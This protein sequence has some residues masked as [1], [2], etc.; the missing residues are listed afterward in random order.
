MDAESRVIRSGI[1]ALDQVLQGIWLGDN[2]VWQIEDLEIYQFFARPFIAQAIT[3]G[4]VCVYLR[5][6][7]HPPILDPQPGLVIIELDPSPGFDYFSAEVHRIIEEKGRKVFYVFD[8]LSALVAEWTTDELLANFFQLTCPYL[9]ELDTVA[10]F[11]LTLGKHHDSAVSRIRDTTQ[12]LIN[13]YGANGE[14]YLHPQK[15]WSRYSSQMFMP[16]VIQGNKIVPIFHSGD[17]AKIGVLSRK[18]PLRAGAESIAPWESVYRKLIQY[19]DCDEHTVNEKPEIFSLKQELTHMLLGSTPPFSDLA[20][21]YFTLKDLFNIRSRIIGSGRIGGKASGMLL[22]RR[23]LLRE[24]GDFDFHP[25]ID[26]HDSFYIGSDVFFTF[27]V[28]NNLF[29]LRM[30]LSRVKQIS[31]HDEFEEVERLFLEAHFNDEI[32][33]QFRNMLD[34][35]GQAPIIVRSSSFL[36]DSF[37]NAF[38]GKYRS[39]FCANQGTPEQRLESFLRAVKLVYASALN[40]DAL[41]YRNKRGLAD[42]D[43]QMALLVQRV[44]GMPFK[45]YFF[46]P[47]AGVAF[48]RNLY[49]WTD[50]IDPNKGIIRLVFGLGTRAVDRIGGDYPR[51]IAVSHPELRPEKGDKVVKYSQREI[52]LLDLEKNDLVTMPVEEI[53]SNADYPNQHLFVSIFKDGFLD[54]PAFV[55]L[56]SA[57]G[58]D[59][60]YS[61]Y[62][63]TFNNLIRKS[64]FV[65]IIGKMLAKLEHY[66]GLPVDTEFTAY[67]DPKGNCHVNLL[68]CRPLGLPGTEGRPAVIPG[69]ISPGDILFRSSRIVSSGVVKNV[70][71]VI[72]IDPAGYASID[73]LETKKLMGRIVGRINSH[74]QIIEGKSM[75]MGPGRWGSSNIDM[76][77]NAH[78]SDIGNTSVLVEIA[79]EEAGQVPEVSY[80][81]HFFQDLVEAKIVYLPVYP[82]DAKTEFNA[83][84][85]E[86]SPNVLAELFPDSIEYKDVIKVI[87]VPAATG[88]KSLQVVA[89][90]QTQNAL[91]YLA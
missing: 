27:L 69:D 79:R 52:D 60:E 19:R 85:F 56:D 62:V 41:S 40:P 76:G 67:I 6:A 77:V 63:L 8:S 3:D 37:G 21:R 51:M 71:Y 15:V 47:L 50:R 83:D 88:G 68:Q 75:M 29:R 89:N 1:P 14:H 36:E 42:Q 17:A 22:A 90:L 74:P 49:A 13:V 4:Y 2:V 44:C 18:E 81:T 45:K 38:A 61:E 91:C 59:G 39:E 30:H 9:F 87:D 48:S 43:E 53:L 23:I 46:P 35:F 65:E 80:G 25:F 12:L 28:N 10:Y 11:A 73:S 34:Y 84:F 57:D 26:S 64:K 72:L 33:E 20:D 5:F 86:N 66:Y 82:D 55:L 54:D 78:Y 24:D 16:H 7:S 31:S 58:A 70:R 32:M